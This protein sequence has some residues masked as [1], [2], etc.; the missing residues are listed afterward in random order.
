VLLYVCVLLYIPNT[1]TIK[2]AKY[3]ASLAGT[4]LHNN[5]GNGLREY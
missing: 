1:Q 3:F 2:S 5:K 4:Q